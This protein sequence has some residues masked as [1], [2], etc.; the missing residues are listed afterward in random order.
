MKHLHRVASMFHMVVKI[1][2]QFSN[3]S[4]CQSVSNLLTEKMDTSVHVSLPKYSHTNECLD[5]GRYFY[6]FNFL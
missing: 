3:L 2:V 6:L 1:H 4:V 5:V